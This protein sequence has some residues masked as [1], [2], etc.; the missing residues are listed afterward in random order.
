MGQGCSE[1]GEK[2]EGPQAPVPKKGCSFFKFNFKI[3]ILK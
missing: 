3:Q 1:G 2:S